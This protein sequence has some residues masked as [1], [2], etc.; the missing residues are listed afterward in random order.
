M[1]MNRYHVCWFDHLSW[2]TKSFY[3][4]AEN[5]DQIKDWIVEKYG[6]PQLNTNMVTITIQQGGIT[7]PIIVPN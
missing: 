4:V 1:A 2:N 7:F 3:L 5:E 6:H